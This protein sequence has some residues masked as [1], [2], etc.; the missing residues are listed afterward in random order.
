MPLLLGPAL[1]AAPR[2]SVQREQRK[3]IAIEVVADHESGG[4][5]APF[6]DARALLLADAVPGEAA[7]GERLLVP[8]AVGPL[9]IDQVPHSAQR[10]RRVRAPGRD[11]AEQRPGRLRG[12]ALAA[13]AQ[14]DVHVGGAG[15][16]PPSVG[17]LAL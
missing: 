1:R 9:P 4:E 7:A 13:A 8:A 17:I 11:Q 15:L 14:L 10:L 2:G 6:A 3:A 16:A 5:L 12:G